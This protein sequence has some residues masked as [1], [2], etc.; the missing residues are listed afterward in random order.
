GIV[1]GCHR[2]RSAAPGSFCDLPHITPERVRLGFL[3]GGSNDPFFPKTHPVYGVTHRGL[4]MKKIAFML[5]TAATLAAA[6]SAPAEARGVRVARPAAA[7]AVATAAAIAADAYYSGG[8]YYHPG[9]VYYGGP[10]YGYGYPAVR[11]GW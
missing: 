7:I 11:Y 9:V 10:A 6:V 8:Y 1:V 4:Q 5:V 2:S 3:S